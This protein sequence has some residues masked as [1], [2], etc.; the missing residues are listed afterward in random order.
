MKSGELVVRES[1]QLAVQQLHG[2]VIGVD[3]AIAMSIDQPGYVGTGIQ[4]GRIPRP[5]DANTISQL[6]ASRGFLPEKVAADRRFARMTPQSHIS[7]GI[8]QSVGTETRTSGIALT[9]SVI[10]LVCSA[11][12]DTRTPYQAYVDCDADIAA[13]ESLNSRISCLTDNQQQLLRAR[14]QDDDAWLTQ[15]QASR[16]VIKRLHEEQMLS[17]DDESVLMIVG[18]GQLGQPVATSVQMRR[19]RGRWK[20]DYE[21]SIA[22][23]ATLGDGQPAQVE[24]KPV[25]GEPW[26]PG[27]L[28][29][30]IYR[31]PDGDCQLSI[32][33]VFEYPMIRLTTDC[34][35]FETA[36]TYA[37]QDLMSAG[38]ES[39]GTTSVTLYDVRHTWFGD[40]DG[41]QL[42]ITGTEGGLLFRSVHVRPGE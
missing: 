28:A 36:G 3:I 13:A 18:H 10:V 26:Y 27:E 37:A 20:I 29:G 16:P 1:M 4:Q 25:N 11:C 39:S 40:V 9:S 5:F 38:T 32:A 12:S 17:N 30:S 14:S 22:K 15:Y 31:R 6:C 35:K 19:D 23:G 42:T 21:E 24:L 2:A 41:G 8:M 7:R 33:H 34:Q